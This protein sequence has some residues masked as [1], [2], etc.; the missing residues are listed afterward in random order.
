METNIIYARSV[1]TVAE[2]LTFAGQWSSAN[3]QSS[4]AEVD[5]SA[6]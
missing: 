1:E 6:K 5:K 3:L 2:N 4:K